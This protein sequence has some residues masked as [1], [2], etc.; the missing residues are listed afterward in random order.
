MRTMSV[1]ALRTFS[2]L[3]PVLVVF[4]GL[5]FL[6]QGARAEF[7][8]YYPQELFNKL[9]TTSNKVS[10]IFAQEN[11]K[12]ELFKVISMAHKRRPG[13]H[14][15]V[16]NVCLE[17][18]GTT[19]VSHKPLSYQEA[20]KYLFGQI[21]LE[22]D[23]RGAFIRDVYCQKDFRSTS[24]VGPMSIP[25]DT[26]INCEHTWPQSKFTTSFPKD[27][28]K[29]DLHH[30]YP[31][32]SK[33]NG[34]RGN[35]PFGEVTAGGALNN[36]DQSYIG[37]VQ[38]NAGGTFFEP[39][40]DHKGNVARAIFYFSVRYK[41]PIDSIQEKYLRQWHQN[42]PV[43]QDETSRNDQIEKV[44]GNRNPFIDFPETVSQISDF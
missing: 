36:C 38:E 18:N 40:S 27:T 24:G 15:E 23:G 6:A 26:E 22:K 3:V 1:T 14:D 12:E 11:L 13:A 16:V 43:D 32:D 4:L 31:S 44:Q 37:G 42:D 21:H 2:Y 41:M 33:A 7:P 5:V 9:E 25:K 17:G 30:L 34:T 8:N 29:S 39:P 19:C 10:P 35:H 20:R 28:Q